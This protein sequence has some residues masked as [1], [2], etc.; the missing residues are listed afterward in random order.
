MNERKTFV[1]KIVYVTVIAILLLPLSYLSQPATTESEGGQL[2]RFR[3]AHELSQANLGEIDPAGETM[4][5]ATLGLRGVAANLLWEKANH[6]KKVEDWTSLSATLE[7]ITRLQPNF[8]SVWQFQGWNLAYNVG[9]EFDDYHDRYQWIIKGINFIKRGARYNSR[10]PRLLWDIGWD[11]GHKIGTADEK[12]LYRKLFREDDD[13]HREDD[14]TRRKSERDNWLVGAWWFEKVEKLVEQG[15]PF[16]GSN[17]QGEGKSPLTF[18]SNRPMCQINYADALEDDGIFGEVARLAW[19]KAGKI[20]NEYANRDLTTTY[21]TMIRLGDQERLEQRAKEAVAELA[22]LTPSGLAEQIRQEHIEKLPPEARKLLEIPRE[23][24]TGKDLSDGD[25]LENIIKPTVFQIAERVDAAQRQKALQL[26]KNSVEDQQV[27]YI[28][29]RY[30]DIVNFTYWRTRCEMEREEDTLAARKAI[31]QADKTFAKA[32]LVEAGRLFDEGFQL[33]AKVLNRYPRMVDESTITDELYD[34]IDRYGSY[35]A[36]ADKKFPRDFVLK[37]LVIRIQ[38]RSV[39]VPKKGIPANFKEWA[40]GSPAAAQPS[41]PDK[42]AGD[43][44]PAVDSKP[45]GD[46]KPADATPA[47]A[48]PSDAK[49]AEAKPNDAKPAADAKPTDSKPTDVKPATDAKP[50]KD[51]Q[52]PTSPTADSSKPAKVKPADGKKD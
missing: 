13:F 1:R 18:Y 39:G 28:I 48:K 34:C 26:A 27:A 15:V 52:A 32:N 11:I 31:Y 3:Q 35:L 17:P 45:S 16:R 21:N 30:R 44:K 46:A 23:K 29:D 47:E 33:W 19:E 41:S 20:W 10:E 9:V 14:P 25:V 24:R 8:I 51:A 42:P 43:S 7:Q 6:F 36:Q 49:P 22:K 2:A 4:K 12:V 50:S 5:L 38:Q 37:D 40:S